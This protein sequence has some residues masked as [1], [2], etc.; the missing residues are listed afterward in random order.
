[1]KNLRLKLSALDSGMAGRAWES[2]QRLRIGRLETWR[3]AAR[4]LGQPA[5]RRSCS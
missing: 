5:P 1:M 3:V 2:D 4:H